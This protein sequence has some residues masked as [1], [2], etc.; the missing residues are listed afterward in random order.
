M[1]VVVGGD[2][3]HRVVSDEAQP[4]PVGT[5]KRSSP[6]ARVVRMRSTTSPTD[7]VPMVRT[8]REGTPARANSSHI[9]RVATSSRNPWPAR[10]LTR[11][12]QVSPEGN[13]IGRAAW[14]ARGGQYV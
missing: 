1:V 10:V 4:E 9:L 6:A 11:C 12:T 14:R 8:W 3:E 2:Q 5:V 7:S 13:T